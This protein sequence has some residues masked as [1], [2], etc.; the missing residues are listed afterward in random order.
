MV[1]MESMLKI[2]AMI[3]RLRDPNRRTS[4]GPTTAP[5]VPS[6]ASAV[7]TL[8]SASVAP[9]DWA[10]NVRMALSVTAIITV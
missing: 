8:K 1:G 4:R 9:S 6:A 10:K 5:I 3:P 2:A 7:I